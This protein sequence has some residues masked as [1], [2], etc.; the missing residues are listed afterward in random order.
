MCRLLPLC[1]TV[2]K[3][4]KFQI[5]FVIENRTKSQRKKSL[6][7]KRVIGCKRNEIAEQNEK[8][9]VE[10]SCV[11]GV[12]HVCRDSPCSPFHAVSQVTKTNNTNGMI[13]R[14]YT[15]LQKRLTSSKFVKYWVPT[16]ETSIYQYACCQ[17]MAELVY[18]L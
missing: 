17:C 2:W 12:W 6:V 4:T 13:L 15:V 7:C 5:F 8:W 16:T 9:Y 1:F 3:K 10:S 14:A 11:N 18:A